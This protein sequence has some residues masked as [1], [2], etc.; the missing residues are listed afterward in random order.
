MHARELIELAAVTAVYSRTI[1]AAGA[2]VT[3]ENLEQYWAAA[4]CR[5]DRWSR[6]LTRLAAA[7]PVLANPLLAWPRIQ[8]VLEE[9]LLSELPARIWAATAAANDGLHG[10][11]DF[12]PVA[13]NVLA[14]HLDVRRRLLVLLTSNQALSTAQVAHLDQLRRRVERW[15]DML[16]AHLA[17]RIDIREFA[18]E[19]NRA[20]DFAD[21]LR[22]NEDSGEREFAC[23]LV[24]ASLR[25]SFA[26]GLADRT[27]NSDLNRRIGAAI[28]SMIRDRLDGATGLVKSLWLE[29]MAR[30]ACDTE[31][32][33]EELLRL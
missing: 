2:G 6:L 1:V 25:A 23:Q 24:L 11:E 16:L 7:D 15:G 14:G 4:K 26:Q 12:E 22:R 3:M 8:P 29:Q 17:P 31:E 27:P 33:I 28:L 20:E 9:L 10:G 19:P 32:M 21:D 5:L 13:R 30:T 18:F